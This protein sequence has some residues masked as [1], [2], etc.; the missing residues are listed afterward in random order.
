MDETFFKCSECNYQL[1]LIE[2]FSDFKVQQVIN[3]RFGLTG[4]I[5]QFLERNQKDSQGRTLLPSPKNAP[6]LCAGN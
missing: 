6:H 3:W 1:K 2:N 4:E 5:F